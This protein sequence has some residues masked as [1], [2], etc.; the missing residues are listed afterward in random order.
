MTA[1]ADARL[2]YQNARAELV[3]AGKQALG[4]ALDNLFAGNSSVEVVVWGQKNGEYDDEGL[5][6]GIMGPNSITSA[7]YERL[8]DY[9]LWEVVYDRSGTGI[10]PALKPLSVVLEQ[11]GSELL[12]DIVGGDEHY[13]IAQRDTDGDGFS[14]HSEHAE[15]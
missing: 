4:E 15:Y 6:P 5:Y 2:S 7:E 3:S 8:G 9:E 13:V 10:P 14:L 1:L 12:A 11:L